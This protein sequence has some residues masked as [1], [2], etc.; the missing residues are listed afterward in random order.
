MKRKGSEQILS[1][2]SFKKRINRTNTEGPRDSSSESENDDLELRP[3]TKKQYENKSRRLEFKR[4]A[5]MT[6]KN[7]ILLNFE[8][9][10]GTTITS[11]LFDEDATTTLYLRHGTV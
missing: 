5:E 2:K 4:R 1:K 11:P 9:V 3:Q 6:D 10:I 7:I 8:G